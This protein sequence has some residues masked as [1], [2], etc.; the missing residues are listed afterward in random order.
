MGTPTRTRI[1]VNAP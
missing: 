1:N